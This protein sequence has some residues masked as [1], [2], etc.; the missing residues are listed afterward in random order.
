MSNAITFDPNLYQAYPMPDM[1][2][3]NQLWGNPMMRPAH[4]GFN[5]INANHNHQHMMFSQQMP[6][7]NTFPTGH[8]DHAQGSGVYQNGHGA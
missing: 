1:Y 5:P 8:H 4:H 2:Q 3:F 7:P 6:M